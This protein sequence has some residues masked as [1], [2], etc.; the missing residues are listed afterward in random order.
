ML[1]HLSSSFLFALSS[2]WTCRTFGPIGL[3]DRF[4][5]F[6][7]AVKG[8]IHSASTLTSFHSLL[9]AQTQGL[10]QGMTFFCGSQRNRR[11]VAASFL[12]PF[13]S[14]FL[15]SR[16]LF[17]HMVCRCYAGVVDVSTTMCATQQHTIDACSSIQ[18]KKRGLSSRQTSIAHHL[19][20]TRNFACLFSP[21]VA[22]LLEVAALP[23]GQ[24]P[25]GIWLG[26]R[27]LRV[28]ILGQAGLLL[29]LLL[30]PN[31]P[32]GQISLRGAFPGSALAGPAAY[33]GCIQ[34]VMS[35][36]CETSCILRRTAFASIMTC[37]LLV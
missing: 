37:D 35:S 19:L 2:C 9:H 10:T 8:I 12:F 6:D 33:T 21:P 16:M 26:T 22:L 18:C 36:C 28:K 13:L 25:F 4:I 1:L 15:L 20:T 5:A 32:I 34:T 11:M 7:S 31:S 29:P 17:L 3:R 30:L 27:I 14:L 23:L 24:P